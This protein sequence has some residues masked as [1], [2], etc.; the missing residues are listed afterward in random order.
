MRHELLQWTPEMVK[1]FWDWQS[2]RPGEYFAERYAGA[3]LRLL[4]PH[5]EPGQPVLDYACGS[6][7]LVEA[8]LSSGFRTAGLDISRES[9]ERVAQRLAGRA[10]FLG[11]FSPD[12]LPGLSHRFAAVTVLEA[13][14]HLYDPQLDALLENAHSL[15]AEDGLLLLTTPNEEDLEKSYVLCPVSNQLFHRY[16]HVRSWSRETL[17]AALEARGFEV[18][19]CAGTDLRRL[20]GPGASWRERWAAL[21]FRW[22]GLRRPGRTPPHLIALARPRRAAATPPPRS[23]PPAS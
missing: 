18:L 3:I 7:R 1:N 16:Q 10:G 15:L 14:E 23:G 21:R 12:E 4:A 6:G 13:V 11:V 17:T 19:D 9:R 2:S 20:A 8:L 5:L 22:K